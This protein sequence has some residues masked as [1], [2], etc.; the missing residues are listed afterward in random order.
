MRGSE[1]VKSLAE[2][3]ALDWVEAEGVAA[4]EDALGMKRGEICSKTLVDV[5]Y[6]IYV[7][8]APTFAYKF[9]PIFHRLSNFPGFE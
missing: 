8:R 4:T 1:S 6:Y 3:L 7:S 5:M 2:A 9:C